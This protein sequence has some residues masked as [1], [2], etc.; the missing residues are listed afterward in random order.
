MALHAESTNGSTATES[1]PTEAFISKQKGAQDMANLP[2]PPKFDDPQ[3]ERE[4]VKGRLAAAFRIFGKY[5]YDEG[6]AGHITYRVD[7]SRRWDVK[8]LH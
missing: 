5:G 2:L 8:V 3:K 7:V 6:V 4:Y 1:L